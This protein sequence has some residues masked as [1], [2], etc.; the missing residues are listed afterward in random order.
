LVEV[1]NL[2]L[3]NTKIHLEKWFNL[4]QRQYLFWQPFRAT[5]FS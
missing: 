2:I 1:I 4:F 3:M 5:E